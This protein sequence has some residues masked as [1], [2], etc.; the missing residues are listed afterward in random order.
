MG[1]LWRKRSGRELVT[2]LTWG[3]GVNRDDNIQ[4][5][6]YKWEV[7]EDDSEFIYVTTEFE[8]TLELTANYS[9]YNLI[10]YYWIILVCLCGF[11][12]QWWNL[13]RFLKHT[14]SLHL[15]NNNTLNELIYVHYDCTRK[16]RPNFIIHSRI[17]C[18]SLQNF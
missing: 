10:T 4:E 6:R 18:R 2:F 14:E 9:L 12:N 5:S 11:L 1:W 15:N 7:V 3:I 8:G 17:K 16:L 13:W